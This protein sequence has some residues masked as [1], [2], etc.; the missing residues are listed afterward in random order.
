MLHEALRQSVKL[1]LRHTL[2]R[3]STTFFSL[4]PQLQTLL[5][6]SEEYNI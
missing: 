4:S 6:S 2:D 3:I 5:A 1:I